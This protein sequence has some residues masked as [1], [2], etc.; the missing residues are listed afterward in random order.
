[1]F[2]PMS[3][4]IAAKSGVQA[5]LHPDGIFDDPNGG[6]LREDIY[7]RLRRHFQFVNVKKLFAEI[8]HWVSYSINAY[9]EK[10]EV[11]EFDM[12]GNLFLPKT[13][14]LCYDHSGCGQVEGIKNN[15]NQ[16]CVKGHK[17]RIIRVTGEVLSLFAKLYDG[18]DNS[19]SHARL[20]ILHSQH[21]LSVLRK[22]ADAPQKLSDFQ[23][24]YYA[25]VMWDETN[26]QK[27]G[28]L[29]R[30]T[31]F[32]EKAEQFVISGPHFYVGNPFYKTPS[33]V[34]AKHHDYSSTDLTELPDDYL[35]RTNYTPSISKDVRLAKTPVVSWIEKGSSERK[36]VTEYYRLAFRRRLSQSGERT[37]ICC[38]LPPYVGHIDTVFSMVFQIDEGLLLFTGTMSSITS[39][40]FVKTTGKDDFRHDLAQL[41][42]IVEQEKSSII[43]RV[44]FLNALTSAYQPLWEKNYNPSFPSERWLKSDP[45]LFNSHFSALTSAWSCNVALRTDYARR[46]ALVELDVLVARALGLTLKELLTIYRVQFPVMRQYEAD[47][48]YDAAGRI[49]FTASKGLVGVGLPRK[50]IKKEKCYS[51]TGPRREQR[52]IALGWEDIRDLKEGTVTREGIDDTLPG[53]PRKKTI[54]YVAPFDRCNREDDYREVWGNLE[55]V[56]SNC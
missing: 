26:T 49:V 25:T 24:E 12:I 38:I 18:E 28:T 29:V 42:P 17:E 13:I 22:M 55:K 41:L 5:F 2:L 44:L 48:W 34:C 51:I 15:E 27:D 46:Q 30:K 11:P 33:K 8:L 52:G 31:V 16:W 14:D 1:M 3:W 50:A 37:L 32:P 20:P 53:G 4:H 54:T 23:N 6:I 19:G 40:F 35:P 36:R 21:Y 47:T 56:E 10:R 39:D 43:L 7:Q 9:G 45:R